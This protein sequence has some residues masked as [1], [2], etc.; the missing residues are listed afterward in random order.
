MTPRAVVEHGPELV[1]ADVAEVRNHE[2]RDQCHLLVDHC[3]REMMVVDDEVP[4]FWANYRRHDVTAKDLRAVV[5][6]RVTPLAALHIDLA[7]AQRHLRRPQFCRRDPDRQNVR[8]D[9][10]LL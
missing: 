2:H 10:T 5:I 7:K 8:H 4:T 3:L 6:I 9:V 1:L